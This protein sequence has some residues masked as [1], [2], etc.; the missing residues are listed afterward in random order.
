M[1]RPKWVLLQEDVLESGL[2]LSLAK[3]GSVLANATMPDQ[4]QSSC[5]PAAEDGI[6]PRDLRAVFRERG[7]P[8]RRDGLPQL[9]LVSAANRLLQKV[10]SPP[11]GERLQELLRFLHLLYGHV[12]LW[13][14]GQ[15]ALQYASGLH[16]LTS[17]PCW[18]RLSH[19]AAVSHPQSP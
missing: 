17:L 5:A 12:G 4:S 3:H 8:R 11:Q 19:P 14:R 15:N 6:G 13:K 18:H 9:A 7:L 2:C 1:I 10:H 16:R